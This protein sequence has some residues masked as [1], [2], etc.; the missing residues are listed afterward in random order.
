M[1]L[2]LR[3]RPLARRRQQDVQRHSSVNRR[4]KNHRATSYGMQWTSTVVDTIQ[5][6]SSLCDILFYLFKSFLFRT[7][8]MQVKDVRRD[9]RNQMDAL[10]EI[11]SAV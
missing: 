7:D 8:Q 9:A 4:W 11:A 1:L 2:L 10:F 5:V 6:Y 3:N